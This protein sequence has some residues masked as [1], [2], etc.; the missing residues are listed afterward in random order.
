MSVVNDFADTHPSACV[1]GTD[2][3]PIQPTSVPPNLQFEIDD[4]EDEW[5]YQ[6]DSFDM[7]HVR[8]LYGCVTDW[9]RFYEQALRHVMQ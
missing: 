2:L 5:L 1:I 8:G 3:S 9:D 7:V 6:E 4:C